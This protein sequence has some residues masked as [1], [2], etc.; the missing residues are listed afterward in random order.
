MVAGNSCVIYLVTMRTQQEA[1]KPSHVSLKASEASTHTH[2]IITSV[3]VCVSRY[4][5]TLCDCDV[6]ERGGINSSFK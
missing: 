2:S 4:E 6:N 3:R 1:E 5:M